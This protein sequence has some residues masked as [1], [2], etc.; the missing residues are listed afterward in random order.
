MNKYLAGYLFAGESLFSINTTGS[1]APVSAKVEP[2]ATPADKPLEPAIAIEPAVPFSKKEAL[3]KP[4][5]LVVQ[6]LSETER[7]FLT[8]IL[9]SVK[10]NIENAEIVEMTHRPDARL[11][12]FSEAKE[13]ISFGVVMNKLGSD[14]LLFPY[15]SQQHQSVRYLF[16]D[17]LQAIQ[18]NQ[19]DEK[20]LLWA[21]LKN[22]YQL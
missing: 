8:K 10:Q 4:L 17:D 19:K 22:M 11:A 13:I 7:A 9:L 6:T 14:L 20:R 3:Q 1:A 12:H 18:S 2:V 21:A 5:V 15:Q 16:V